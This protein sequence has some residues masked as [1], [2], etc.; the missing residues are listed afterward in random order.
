MARRAGWQRLASGAG[1][2]D[3]LTIHQDAELLRTALEP[4]GSR[5]YDLFEGRHAWVQWLA[6][7]GAVNG[8]ALAAGDGLAVSD[9]TALSVSAGT[10]ADILLFDLA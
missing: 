4:G 5:R 6:G 2:D 9:E 8:V 3:A 7:R 1:R 10:D